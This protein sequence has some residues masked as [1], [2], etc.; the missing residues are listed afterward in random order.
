MEREAKRAE[1]VRGYLGSLFKG[2]FGD[3]QI[4]TDSLRQRGG[5][6]GRSNVE[7]L[8]INKQILEGILASNRFLASINK[9]MYGVGSI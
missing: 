1:Y 6:T 5:Y 7:T 9:S 2:I 8:N 3:T 4:R